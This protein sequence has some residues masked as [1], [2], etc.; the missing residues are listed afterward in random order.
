MRKNK[1]KLCVMVALFV[2]LNIIITRFLS[3]QTPITRIGF[4]FAPNALCSMMLGPVI[5]ALS[6]GIADVLGVIIQ[7]Q[8]IFP[9][10]TVNAV[11]HGLIYGWFLYQRERSWKNVTLC[12]VTEIVFVELLLGSLW[13]YLYLGGEKAMLAVFLSRLV[14]CAVMLPIKIITIHTLAKAMEH[15]PYLKP[16]KE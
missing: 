9:G 15:T 3:I 11:L 13:G 1:T 16:V 7:G 4:G 5:G 12:V 14:Q 6:A 8:A 10:Y 2:A